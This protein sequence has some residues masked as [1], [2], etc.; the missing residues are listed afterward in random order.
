MTLSYDEAGTGPTLVLL[1]SGVCDRRMW[2]P[3]WEP[4]L[5]AGFR[6]VRV[7][8]PG[9]GDSPAPAPGYNEAE[10]V[11]A[12][13]GGLGVADAA[14]VGSSYGGRIA[15]EVAARWPDRV[16]TLALLCAAR[17]GRAPSP[18]LRAFYDA[19]EAA[20]AAGDLDAA[21]ECNMA[22][23]VGPDADEPTRALVRTMCRH[24]LSRE[25]AAGEYQPRAEPVDVTAITARTLVVSGG[26]D[27]VDFQDIAVELAG[28]VPDVRHVALPW[29]GH[30]PSLERPAE[31]TALLLDF[32]RAS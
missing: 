4:L 3:Q 1:H 21:V 29:A 7:D 10:E 17:A 11:A 25:L 2:A 32:L 24:G 9:F 15:Q 31:T 18:A 13:L 14:L 19:E 6:V 20:L 30:F 26:H 16:T 28:L 8:L 12:L 27:L 5:D 22:T 23:W